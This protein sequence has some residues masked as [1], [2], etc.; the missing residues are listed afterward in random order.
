MPQIG[1]DYELMEEMKA[2]LQK[3]AENL[4]TIKCDVVSIADELDGG[5]LRGVAGDNLSAGLNGILVTKIKEIIDQFEE[6]GRDIQYAI[7]KTK[8]QDASA[9]SNMGW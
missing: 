9:A 8:E 2:A 3:G 5:A 4:E 7:D 1:M 6:L